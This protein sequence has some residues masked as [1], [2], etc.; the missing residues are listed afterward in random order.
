MRGTESMQ[1]AV[2]AGF[3]LLVAGLVS[4]AAMIV[5]GTVEKRTG[6]ASRAYEVTG[7][8]RDFHGITLHGVLVLPALAWCLSRTS[9]SEATRCRLVATAIVCYLLTAIAVLSFDLATRT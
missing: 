5:R 3:V 8:I 7:F 2:R 1:L 6:T 4:G 9:L